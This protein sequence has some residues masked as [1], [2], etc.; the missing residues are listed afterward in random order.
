MTQ[1]AYLS[2]SVEIQLSPGDVQIYRLPMMMP[3]E[4]HL[5]CH[6]LGVLTQPP[7]QPGGLGF[8]L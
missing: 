8:P 2:P 1:Y 5:Y 6:Q 7:V 4:F 3:G